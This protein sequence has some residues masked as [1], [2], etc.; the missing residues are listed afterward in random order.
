MPVTGRTWLLLS[1]ILVGW[2]FLILH[3]V[4]FWQ[5]ARAKNVEARWRWLAL[6]PP[7]APVVAWKGG[8]RVAPIL[9]SILL[10]AYLV[11][12]AFES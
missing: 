11:L 1:W 12:R 2:V 7:V 8:R 3:A 9:W 5:A 4:V 10:L 6:I